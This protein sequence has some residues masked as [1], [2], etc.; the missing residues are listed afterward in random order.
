MRLVLADNAAWILILTT[1]GLDEYVCDALRA[2]ASGFVLK[3]DPPEQ[4][5]AAVHT[6]AARDAFL[7]PALVLPSPVGPGAARNLAGGSESG[8]VNP[9]DSWVEVWTAMTGL[10]KSESGMGTTM[11]VTWTPDELQRIGGAPELEI[12][13][14]RADGVLRRWVPIWV[15]STG[16]QVYV[17]TWYRRETGWFGQV[18]A[19]HRARIRVPCLEADV[20]VE[21]VGAGTPGLRAG[22][23]DAYCAKYG[24]FGGTERMVADEAA[25]A[26][27]R[28]SRDS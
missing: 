11:S 14:R 25:A 16:G 20:A 3:D 18:L 15:V 8:V 24:R 19:S 4:L 2:W 26:T 21:D 1:F 27:L 9:R 10:A 28:L 6:V 22:I 13:S 23:D 5:I 17:R 12:A 7:S